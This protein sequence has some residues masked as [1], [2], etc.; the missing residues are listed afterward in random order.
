MDFFACRKGNR[1]VNYCECAK[2]EEVDALTELVA[3]HCQYV[4]FG[5]TNDGLEYAK[6]MREAWKR[7]REI[8]NTP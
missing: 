4:R 8:K 6:Q 3:Q 7:D 5:F 2:K 1:V